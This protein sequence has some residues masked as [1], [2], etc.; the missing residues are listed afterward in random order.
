[1]RRRSI[2]LV[3][4]VVPLIGCTPAVDPQLP[5]DAVKLEGATETVLHNSYSGIV[6]RRRLVIRDPQAW[7]AVWNEAYR[8][9]IP[10]PS[11]PEIDFSRNI[12]IVAGMGSRGTGG[13]GITFD[14]IYE[15][16]DVLYAVVRESAP[17]RSC[18]VTQAL[19]QPVTA[20]RVARPGADVRFIE[21]SETV[22]CGP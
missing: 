10:V 8:R 16:D 1:M 21:R 4:I 5:P 11:V 12:V 14:T 3:A 6:D 20:V 15:A 19:T 7:S 18:I 22:D 17:G 2:H 9:H 13:Y